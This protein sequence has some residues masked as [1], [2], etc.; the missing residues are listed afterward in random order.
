MAYCVSIHPMDSSRGNTITTVTM[1]K[2]SGP[3]IRFGGANS[4]RVLAIVSPWV[5]LLTGARPTD[6]RTPLVPGR[7]SSNSLDP[8]Q[9]IAQYPGGGCTVRAV[10]HRERQID[11]GA[12]FPTGG[13]RFLEAQ[14]TPVCVHRSAGHWPLHIHATT[15]KR[16]HAFFMRFAVVARASDRRC[17]PGTSSYSSNIT[18]DHA[19]S[20]EINLRSKA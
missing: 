14:E 16:D 18:Y 7:S 6:T 3:I 10:N 11:S 9:K 12:R 1:T 5:E 15:R 13:A 4:L 19:F 20:L 17:N 2:S 8:R